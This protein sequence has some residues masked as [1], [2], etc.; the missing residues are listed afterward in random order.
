MFIFLLLCIRQA[1]YR[2]PTEYG[3]IELCDNLESLGHIK[4]RCGNLK[5]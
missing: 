1:I 2:L 3:C 5:S 4:L